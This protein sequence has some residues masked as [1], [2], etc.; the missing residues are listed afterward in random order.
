[1]FKTIFHVDEVSRWELTLCNVQNLLSSGED[2]TIEVLAN[3]EAV[4]IF[5]LPGQKDTLQGIAELA[6]NGVTFAVCNH[7]LSAYQIAREEL[8]PF[9][10]VVPVG[11]L[12]LTRRQAEGYAYIKP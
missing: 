7:A 11:V 2:M 8:S 12:E 9:V 6:Q 5:T 3:A 1:M 4:R 10:T